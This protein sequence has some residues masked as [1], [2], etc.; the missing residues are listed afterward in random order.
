M[1]HKQHHKFVYTTSIASE[2]AHPVEHIL[3]NNL[4]FHVGPILLGSRVH[5]WTVLVWGILRHTESHEAHAGYDFPFSI[6]NVLPFG[7][8]PVYHSFHHAKNVGN[9]STFFTVWDNVFDSNVDYYEI[10]GD[11]NETE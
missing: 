11:T 6:W 4:A 1:F 5:I 2:H 9:Y 3:V 8:G 7:T 10:Y